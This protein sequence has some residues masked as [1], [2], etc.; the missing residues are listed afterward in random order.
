MRTRIIVHLS[1]LLIALSIVTS[2]TIS[3][4]KD[5]LDLSAKVTK[6]DESMKEL[7]RDQLNYSIERDLLKEAFSSN[8]QTIN[9]VLA[10]ILGVFSLIGFLGIRDIGVIKTQYLDELNKLNSL[11]TDF[12]SKISQYQSEQNKVKED[13]FAV[14]KTNEDQ[15]R[16]IK[17]LEL[18]EKVASLVHVRSHQRAL[19]YAILGLE[20]DP[21]NL[22][23]LSNK[24]TCLWRLGDLQGAITAYTKMLEVDPTNTNAVDNLLELHLLAN[25]LDDFQKLYTPNKSPLLARNGP[26]ISVYFEVLQAY[27]KQDVG[28]IKT[29]M[30]DYIASLQSDKE[31]R[32]TWDFSDMQKCLSPKPTEPR[33]ALLNAFVSVLTGN[34]DRNEALKLVTDET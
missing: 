13:Y 33:G 34:M 9:I 28:L 26:S 1:L 8:Y 14:L 27:Q 30:R 23:L 20:M 31:K 6:L 32:T 5:T 16:R 21:N 11:R 12:E 17:V 22:S 3:Q 25:R 19:E 18:Q 4:K 24:G 15:N 7:R 2:T 10:I 29:L